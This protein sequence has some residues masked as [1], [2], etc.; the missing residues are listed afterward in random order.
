V[1]DIVQANL[2][3]LDRSEAD[4]QALNIGSGEPISIAD[5]AATLAQDMNMRIPAEITGKFRAGDIRHCY[6]DISRA[7][8]LLGYEPR[9]T[10]RAG[11]G[12]LVEWLRSQS[13]VDRA[14]E[15]TQE[16]KAY[17]LTA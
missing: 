15:A 7:R 17:G 16:L 11:V 6:A 10:F 12:E 13:P 4:G 9:F 3:A 2:R 8:Q 5:V 14:A 1:H